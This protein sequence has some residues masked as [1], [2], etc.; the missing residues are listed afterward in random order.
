MAADIPKNI[1][2]QIKH[3]IADVIEEDPVKLETN[4]NFW[5]DLGVDSIKAIE[6]SV[7]LEKKLGITIRD[8]SIPKIS[9]V[10]DAVALVKNLLKKKK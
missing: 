7:A 5:N 1:E 6:I 4:V 2:E 10:G 8:E 3:I 9:T